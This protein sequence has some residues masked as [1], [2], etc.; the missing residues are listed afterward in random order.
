M[1]FGALV[2]NSKIPKCL[3]CPIQ[4]NCKFYKSKN[5]IKQVK[6]EVVDK[7]INIFCY[8]SKKGKIALTKKNNLGF[9]YDLFGQSNEKKFIEVVKEIGYRGVIVKCDYD[10]NKIKAFWVYNLLLHKYR[11]SYLFHI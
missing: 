9:Q 2:C 3:I 10:L 6:K 1:E 5:K 11:P 7:D 8:L 4:T